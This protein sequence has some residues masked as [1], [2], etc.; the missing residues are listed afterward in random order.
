MKIPTPPWWVASILASVIFVSIEYVNRNS[1]GPWWREAL[2]KTAALIALGQ[3][4]LYVHFSG[5]PHWL[6]AWATFSIGTAA[7]R[8]FM[9]SQTAAVEV[10]NWPLILTGAATMLAGALLLK[11]GLN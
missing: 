4:C 11:L 1:T 7:F 2:P 9:V 6:T 3:W 5:A 10:T 8:V